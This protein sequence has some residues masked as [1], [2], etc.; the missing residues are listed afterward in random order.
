MEVNLFDD[1]AYRH[2]SGFDLDRYIYGMI[3]WL[4]RLSVWAIR[5]GWL[6]MMSVFVGSV[7]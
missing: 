3:G 6:L 7:V 2:A 4:V 1:G 5:L